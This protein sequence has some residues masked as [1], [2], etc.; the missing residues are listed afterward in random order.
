[1]RHEKKDGGRQKEEMRN[2]SRS[3]GEEENQLKSELGGWEAKIKSTFLTQR[4]E[5]LVSSQHTSTGTGVCLPSEQTSL[6][7]FVKVGE[8]WSSLIFWNHGRDEENK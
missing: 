3:Q 5:L 1:V 6:P 8:F 2:R 7:A 4:S